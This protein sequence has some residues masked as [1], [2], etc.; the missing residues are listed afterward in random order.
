M[1]EEP[2]LSNELRELKSRAMMDI[3]SLT[4]LEYA[5]WRL[6]FITSRGKNQKAIW[7]A[8]QAIRE[9]NQLRGKL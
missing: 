6:D 4:P 7:D 9:L 5:I 8:E 2:Q 3:T 1:N